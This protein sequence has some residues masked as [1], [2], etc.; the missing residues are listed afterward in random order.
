MTIRELMN[1]LSVYS[2]DAEVIFT[3]S[4]RGLEMALEE[5]WG[6]FSNDTQT[7]TARI[8]LGEVIDNDEKEH[9]DA[10]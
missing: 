1:D 5:V 7:P 2:P 9:D 3:N 6:Y 8:F 4:D 10:N